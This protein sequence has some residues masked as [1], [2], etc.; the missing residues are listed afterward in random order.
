MATEYQS[1]PT[2]VAATAPAMGAGQYSLPLTIRA[3][4]LAYV[5]LALLALTLRIASL[6][7]IPLNDYEARQALHA[8]HTVESDAPG[9]FVIA[10]NPLTHLGQ[11]LAFSVLGPSA[12][13]ARVIVAIAGVCLTLSPLL[14]RD[15]FGA[16]RTFVWSAL[17]AILTVP[18]AA[19]RTA[20]GTTFMMLFTILAIWMIRRFWYSQQL[21]HAKIAG[22]FVI[23]MLVLSSPSGIPLLFILL[24]SGWL[25]VWRTALSAPQRLDLP[26]DD[27]LQMS[28]RRLNTFPL[29]QVALVALVVVF[30]TTTLFMLNPGGLQ[31]VG[32]LINISLSRLTQT[33]N[34]DGL[35]VGLIALLT[36]QPLLAV[37]ALGGAWLLWRHGALSY[38]D[39]FAAA[40][41]VVGSLALALYPGALPA[42][43]MWAVLPM[44]I[45]ASYGITQLMINRR[46]AVLWS[47]GDEHESSESH[48]LYST[49]FWWVK[50]AIS[51]GVLLLLLTASVQFLQVS[52]AL[53]DIPA[54]AGFSELVERISVSSYSRLAQGM[55]LLAMTVMVSII[56]YFMLANIWGSGTCLQGIGIGFLW[57]MLLSSLGGA[58]NTS[59]IGA[60]EPAELWNEIA[61]A[62]D[63]PL[64]RQTL[65]ELA[66]RNTNGFPLINITIVTDP[67]G[68]VSDNGLIAWMARDFPNA[69][70]VGSSAEAVADPVVIMADGAE[71]SI[72]LKADYVGQ[73][74]V[75]RRHISLA[76]LD[77]WQLPA[78]WSHRRSRKS[79]I[80]EEAVILWL[81][82]DIYDGNS[83]DNGT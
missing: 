50:W 12:F 71:E 13:S 17:L 59:V 62:K 10:H 29:A 82:Q 33:D 27:I 40:W 4:W 21:G 34:V 49:R 43:S 57:F 74:F 15:T 53:L 6:D 23:A 41:A 28:L 60:N 45:L 58:W 7:S 3:E 55:G 46:T 9:N 36:Y 14:F 24:L 79:N 72:D 19:A 18:V 25:A 22:A 69:R 73:R 64:L 42:D 78:W 77:I 48:D 20:D 61:V 68:I 75:L 2:Q 32:E 63:A 47:D 66:A 37:F 26:G 51:F 38:V 54:D 65:F 44:S 56:L 70:F 80:I 8:W 11:V 31:T 5:F 39:R 16:T 81:R 35:R 30:L 76:K 83:D 67:E 52:R 1:T